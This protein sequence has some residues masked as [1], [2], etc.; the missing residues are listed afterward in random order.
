MR[1]LISGAGIAGPTLAWWLQRHGF[2]PTLIE[3]APSL[4]GGGYVVDF[5]GVGYEVARRMGLEAELRGLGYDI[6]EVRMIDARGRRCGGFSAEVFKQATGGRYTTI[7]RGDLA[8]AIYR[9]LGERVETL[10]GDSIAALHADGDGVQVE[11]EHAPARR[12]D[13]I[14]GA[15]GL[16]S[17]V[18]RLAFGAQSQ[19]EKPLG[20][21]VAAFET[22]GY[23]PR[24]EQVYVGYA[25]PGQQVA[26]FSMHDDRTMFLFVFAHDLV[27]NGLPDTAECKRILHAQFDDAAWECPQILAALD[28]CDE[29]YF[30]RVSQIR[31]P[32]WSSGRVALIGDAASCPSLLAGQGSALAMTQAYVLAGELH[33]A[34]GDYRAAFAAYERRMREFIDTKQRDAAKFAGSFAPRTRLGLTLRNWITRLF[35]IPA[36]AR[37]ALGRSLIDRIELPDYD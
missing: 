21:T 2:E 25:R 5:W 33:A 22:T 20:Y 13:L 4:R 3:H 19:F 15:D 30:D 28:D 9:S 16:H 6:R 8:T 24:D 1:I 36:V 11:F 34:G 23:R 12:Y 18:R 7:A 29:I 27:V 17:R 31:M 10:F 35:A 26:R 37:Y 32:A 14:V